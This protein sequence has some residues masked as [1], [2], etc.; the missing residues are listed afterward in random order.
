MHRG[1]TGYRVAIALLGG[2][3]ALSAS[4]ND[5]GR[6]TSPRGVG[7]I[8]GTARA[9][10]GLVPPVQRA[11]PLVADMTWSFSAGPTGAV[12][13][14]ADAGLTVVVPEGALASTATITVTAL[15]G[16]AVAYRFEPHLEFARDV[17]LIQDLETI[18]ALDRV[19]PMFG[20]HFDGDVPLYL[21]GL[22]ST[23]ELVPAV[24]SA[25]LGTVRLDVRHFSG[26]IVA[27]GNGGNPPPDSSGGGS[28]Q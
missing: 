23:D 15:A 25:L 4:C 21:E 7:P 2:F 27:S 1:F 24:V 19:R 17:T 28:G 10:V 8:A 3:L 14:N 22:A 18:R 5:A 13:Q 20:G 11:T 16:S 6:P 9:V 12:S 26:W